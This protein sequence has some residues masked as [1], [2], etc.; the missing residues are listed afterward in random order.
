MKNRLSKAKN[1]FILSDNVSPLRR[2]FCSAHFDE[3]CFDLCKC[4]FDQEARNEKNEY[5]ILT[6]NLAGIGISENGKLI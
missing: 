2:C 4:L 5:L 3:S 1:R 6:V